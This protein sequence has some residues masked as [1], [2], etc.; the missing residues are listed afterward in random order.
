MTGFAACEIC[1]ATDWRRTYSGTI[2]DGVFGSQCDNAEVARCG[3]C[4]VDRLREDFCFETTGYET[5]EYRRKLAQAANTPGYQQTHDDLQRFTLDALWPQSLRGLTV[6]DVGCAGGSFLDHVSGI[7]TRLVAIE[8][9]RFFHGDLQHR[10]YEVFPSATAAADAIGAVVDLAVSSQVIEHVA[11]PRGFL[12]EIG[13]LLAPQGQ[14]LITTPN[15]DE[16]L[17]DLLPDDYPAFFY[18][19]VHRW[20]FDAGALAACGRAA[21]LEPAETRFVH[22]YPMANTLHWLRDRRPRGRK[23]MPPLD[24]AADGYWKS[25]LEAGGRADQLTMSFRKP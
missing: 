18:R 24:E 16:I 9:A 25:Y 23:P 21:G 6:A 17:M 11:D 12:A 15:R 1:A 5:E 7:A 2:R 13:D 19:T 4:G 3:G 8:P 20:Y 14:L 22:R 10:G